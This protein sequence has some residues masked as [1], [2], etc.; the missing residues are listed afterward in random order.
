M[1]EHEHDGVK[2][3]A[4]RFPE[5]KPLRRRPGRPAVQL[6][7]VLRG[8]RRRVRAGD[9][10][11]NSARS[12]ITELKKP[13][14][15]EAEHGGVARPG[16]AAGAA[17]ALAALADPLVTDAVL[18]AA[19]GLAEAR[20]EVAELVAFVKTLGTA[21]VELDVTDKEYRLDVVWEIK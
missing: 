3:V 17:D 21:R 18:G 12:S 14:K 20:K 9:D 1:T 13:Q 19:I 10:R 4:Y 16:Y 11:S 5:N 8:R 6:R 7:A 2:I 15:R